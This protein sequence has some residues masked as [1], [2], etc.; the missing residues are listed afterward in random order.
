M[1]ST[2][3]S[4]TT[5]PLTVDVLKERARLAMTTLCND[6]SELP[7][8]PITRSLAH[9]LS[10]MQHD[11]YPPFDNLD[12]YLSFYSG[13]LK[14]NPSFHCDVHD[15]VAEL[16]AG[17]KG[18]GKAWVFSTITGWQEGVGAKESVDMM[19]FDQDGMLL[20]NK[21]VQRPTNKV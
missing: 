6:R 3:T 14:E 15:V 8:F 11:D 21:D 2:T 12:A 19:V 17:G 1:S 7:N 10:K 13:H 20:S 16:V 9:P 4:T 18:G 5:Q